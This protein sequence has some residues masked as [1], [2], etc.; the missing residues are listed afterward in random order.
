MGAFRASH[1]IAVLAILAGVLLAMF[2]PAAMSAEMARA[3]GLGVAT[4][5]LLAT[6][7]LPEHVTAILFFLFAVLFAVAPPEII[8]AGFHSS[9]FWLVFGGLIIGLGVR[10]TGLAE[11]LAYAIARS[12]GTSYAA[13][14]GGMVAIGVVLAFLMPSTMARVLL[15]LPIVMA[16]AEGFGF[17]PGSKG[18]A[19]MVLAASFGTML[20]AFT[21]LPAAL[22]AVIMAGTS[23]TLYG[24]APIYGDFLLLHFPVLGFL[25]AV[26]IAVMIVLLFPDTPAVSGRS[27]EKPQPM[28]RDERIMSLL[29]ALALALWVTDFLHHV[30]PAWVA[31][32]VASI[33]LLPAVGLVPAQAFSEKVNYGSLFYVAGV[34][35]LGAL[36]NYSGTGEL[37]ARAALD[38]VALEPGDTV[39]T[40]GFVAGLGTLIAM[41]AT[42]PAVP[43]IMTPLSQTIADAAA[44]P[45]ET[46]LM[47]QVVGFST[48]V[49]PYQTPPLV[50]AMQV[51]NVPMS[52]GNKLCLAVLAV[53]VFLLIPLDFAWWWVLGRFG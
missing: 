45:I 51:G 18:R 16:M 46:V 6:G 23:E 49:L 30:S 13:I 40:F 36:L 2:P 9:A 3:T 20:P 14:I 4:I 44:L 27:A 35:G 7:A 31:L 28:Q 48:V 17:Q 43:I 32:G 11:R 42:Q 12:L 50:V 24:I 22:P 53:T 26:T 47:M 8:F 34:L 5:G 52:Q 15:L 33:L 10:R 38:V 19:G 37:L 21:I 41:V 39:K 25:K 29:L 1:A